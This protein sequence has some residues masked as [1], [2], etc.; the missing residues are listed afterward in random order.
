MVVDDASNKAGQDRSQGDATR[1][2]RHVPTGRGGRATAAVC[3]DSRPDRPV[4]DSATEHVWMREVNELTG[5]HVADEGVVHA[6]G[7]LEAA[8]ARV[9]VQSRA[10]S[11]R[12]G[13]KDQKIRLLPMTSPVKYHK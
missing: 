6:E 8:V 2:V 12:S 3:R 7:G 11:L 9:T 5:G 13:K 4:G 10:S 1:Q